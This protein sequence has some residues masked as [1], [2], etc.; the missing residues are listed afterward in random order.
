[1]M[2]AKIKQ[3]GAITPTEMQKECGNMSISTFNKLKPYLMEEY[4]G[5]IDY[6]RQRKIFID[7]NPDDKMHLAIQEVLQV[8]NDSNGK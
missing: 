3:F 7:L 1:M 8:G 5:N 2:Y 6:V 4:E